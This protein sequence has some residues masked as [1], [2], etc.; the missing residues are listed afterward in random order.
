MPSTSLPDERYHV[1]FVCT[2]NICRS[3]MAALVFGEH[4]RRSPFAGQVRVTSAGTGAW[5]LGEPADPRAAELLAAHGYPTEHTASDLD[6]DRAGADLFVALDSGHRRVLLRRIGDASRVRLLRSFDPA[7]TDLEVPDP[8]YGDRGGFE[9]VLAAVEAAMP[10]LLAWIGQRLA[11][12]D[13]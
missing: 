2:G 9:A 11:E 6:K 4:L 7:A 5:H 10:G 12:R 8:Y 3:P 13:R 1:C